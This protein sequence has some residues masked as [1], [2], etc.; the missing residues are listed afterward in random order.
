MNFS[1]PNNTLLSITRL[2]WACPLRMPVLPVLMLDHH[3]DS[4]TSTRTIQVLG[5]AKVKA[6]H[7]S[8][9]S[10]LVTA[11]ALRLSPLLAVTWGVLYLRTVCTRTQPEPAQS[12]PG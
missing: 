1:L 8:S 3:A 10:V 2:L 4:S 7:T 9:M 6:K 5:L 12:P 11:R